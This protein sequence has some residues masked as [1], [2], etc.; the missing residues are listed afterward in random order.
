MISPP[1]LLLLLR[2]L[3]D[4]RLCECECEYCKEDEITTEEDGGGGGDNIVTGD[5]V[6]MGV[7]EE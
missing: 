2:A 3:K 1:S 6:I 5:H 7:N 4:K